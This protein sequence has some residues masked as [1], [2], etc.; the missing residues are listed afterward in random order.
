MSSLFAGPQSL[1][2]ISVL[3]GYRGCHV[4]PD[5]VLIHRKP[6][7]ATLR[8]APTWFAQRGVR[9]IVDRRGRSGRGRP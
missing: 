6:D 9:L 5:L 3:T 2:P 1:I 7:A 8:L 4:K